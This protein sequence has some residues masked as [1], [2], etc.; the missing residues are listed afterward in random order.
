MSKYLIVLILPLVL[1]GSGCSNKL[2][3][4]DNPTINVKP[5][6]KVEA[7]S[8]N[9][10]KFYNGKNGLSLSIPSG[11]RSTCIWTWAAGS[12]R[13]PY[14]NTTKAETATEKH[15]VIIYGDEENF[16][17]SCFDDFGNQYVGEFPRD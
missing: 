17:A 5:N 9:I 1:M 13:F 15:T 7:T 11:N 6:I 12:G 10:S 2:K 8:V 4:G 14:S 3:Q 16:K